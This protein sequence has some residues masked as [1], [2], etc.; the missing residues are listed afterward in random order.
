MSFL[1]ILRNQKI[2]EDRNII[3]NVAIGFLKDCIYLFSERG[4]GREKEKERN[5]NVWLLLTCPLLG[6]WPTTQ[7]CALTGNGTSDPLVHGP[8]LNPLSH[9]RQGIDFYI[10]FYIFEKFKYMITYF[11]LIIDFLNVTS[12]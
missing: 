10:C 11:V 9:T 1:V 12:V 2:E 7:A 8:V 4:E 3:I 6:T 5:I